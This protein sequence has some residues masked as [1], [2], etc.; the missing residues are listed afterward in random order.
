MDGDRVDDDAGDINLKIWFGGLK[1]M[2]KWE[3]DIAG[4]WSLTFFEKV[5][6]GHPKRMAYFSKHPFSGAFAVSFREGICFGENATR[7]GGIC[8]LGRFWRVLNM[9]FVGYSYALP[10]TKSRPTPQPPAK[11]MVGRLFSFLGFDLVSVAVL[12]SGRANI[13]TKSLHRNR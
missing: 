11:M 5:K 7:C 8:P 10:T 9:D 6:I 3:K 13:P 4:P 1:H 2:K 12:V